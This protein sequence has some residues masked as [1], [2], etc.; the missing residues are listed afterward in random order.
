MSEHPTTVDG[1]AVECSYCEQMT[2]WEFVWPDGTGER[3]GRW[4]SHPTDA[5]QPN[6]EDRDPLDPIELF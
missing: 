3:V 5:T 1:G 2:G 4:C 6:W